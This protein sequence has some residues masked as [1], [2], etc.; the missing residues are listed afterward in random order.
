MRKFISL[1]FC[2]SLLSSLL[3]AQDVITAAA[4]EGC[5]CMKALKPEEFTETQVSFK[6]LNCLTTH[7][8]AVEAELKKQG[9]FKDEPFEAAIAIRDEA[10]KKCPEEFERLN[11]ERE[12]IEVD[13]ALLKVNNNTEII[14]GLSDAICRCVE[15]TKEK[16]WSECMSRVMN[17]NEDVLET[18]L[19]AHYKDQGIDDVFKMGTL[20]G[21]DIAL[22]LVDQCES[23]GEDENIKRFKAFPAIKDGC[24][25]LIL[26]E[27]AME[28]IL[29][30][31]KAVVTTNRYSEYDSDGKL[32]ED[33]K[34]TW[35]GCTA[36]LVA[37][38]AVE[39]GGVKKGDV[40][41][42]EIKR[43]SEKGFLSV[44]HYKTIPA[45]NLFT[46]KN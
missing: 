45:P 12:K 29:G 39:L 7:R 44:I 11:K 27:Y 5:A 10:Y 30:E 21:V 32:K 37:Q 22:A 14:S 3:N 46:K 31:V 38:R 1:A 9:T 34:L 42:L 16:D 15:I 36:T 18:R 2:F 8:E 24:N 26:G 19:T 28:T 41:K 43:A 40:I 23:L 20:M 25:K 35:K 33:Y 6:I 4:E 13:P 17:A